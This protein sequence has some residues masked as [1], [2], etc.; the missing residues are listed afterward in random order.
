MIRSH[1]PII[2]A[3]RLGRLSQEEVADMLGVS[4]WTYNRLEKGHRSFDTGWLPYM[5]QP[6]REPIADHLAQIHLDEGAR[7]R[8]LA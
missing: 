6:F 7:L 4:V 1:S 8:Q 5:P 3:V 2:S